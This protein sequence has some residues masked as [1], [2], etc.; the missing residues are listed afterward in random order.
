MGGSDALV[1][2]TLC[3]VE[4][5]RYLAISPTVVTAHLWKLKSEER[6]L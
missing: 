5:A 3:A 6:P 2:N 4:V 1:E